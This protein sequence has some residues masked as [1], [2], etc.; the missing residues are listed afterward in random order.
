M[1]WTPNSAVLG[2]PLERRTLVSG[3]THDNRRD[4]TV[5][6]FRAL[7][8]AT[9]DET[10]DNDP[11]YDYWD[12]ALRYTK[13]NPITDPVTGKPGYLSVEYYQGAITSLLDA[14]TITGTLK[15]SVWV[16]YEHDQFDPALLND[17]DE[18][19]RSTNRPLAFRRT[20]YADD[21]SRYADEKYFD[22][23]GLGHYRS[24]VADGNF[25]SGNVRKAYRNTN[26]GLGT[27]KVNGNQLDTSTQDWYTSISGTESPGNSF[28][29]VAA[30]SPWT[31]TTFDAEEDAEP[32]AVARRE[33]C[34]ESWT[35]FLQRTR[36]L[37]TGAN[38][39]V[40]DLLAV[41]SRDTAGNLTSEQYY[42]GDTQSIATGTLC[43]LTPPST[44]Q[45]RIDHT[46]QYGSMKTSRYIDI[47]GTPLSFY[48]LDLDIDR[49]TGRPSASRD[50]AAIR[51]TSRTTT[52]R[53]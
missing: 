17:I 29:M 46:Y 31:L 47:N 50:T 30:T 20:V 32:S 43:S 34:F 13:R 7:P 16:R 35:G 44:N 19:Y 18:D 11:N 3:P 15:R 23:D 42:G 25:D 33:Y 51:P 1:V 36:T 52:W 37:K 10:A 26:A 53:V 9:L 5:Y 28:Q 45:F 39:G 14:A 40:N 4:D 22:L 8:D 48:S 38:R 21:G 24:S 27:Y 41:Y 6:Y 12:Y 49:N 2:V